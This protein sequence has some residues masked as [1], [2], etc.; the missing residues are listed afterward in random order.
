MEYIE[1]VLVKTADVANVL[2]GTVKLELVRVPAWSN[3]HAGDTLVMP[4]N[5]KVYA[6]NSQ[7]VN[8]EDKDLRF[9]FDC[10]GVDYK[11]GYEIPKA[12][13]RLEKIEFRYLEDN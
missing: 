5:R 6:V 7:V 1:V 10:M 8:P 12:E 2:H 3:I 11:N 4:D 9:L 13:A